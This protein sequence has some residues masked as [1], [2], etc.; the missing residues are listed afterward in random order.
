MSQSDLGQMEGICPASLLDTADR[1]PFT[2]FEALRAR[3]QVLR[4]EKLGAW[5]VLD[6]ALCREIEGNEPQFSNPYVGAPASL[7]EVKGGYGNITL[8]HGEEHMRLR[9]FHLKLLGPS[10]TARYR[11]SVVLPIIDQ[12]FRRFENRGH[13]ELVS[14]LA[15]QIPPRVIV[16]LLGMDWQDDAFIAR[17]VHLHEVIM[18]FIG[19]NYPGGETENRALAA[20]RELN[21]ILLP[22]IRARTDGK[23][24]DFIS[25][26]WA[27]A[28]TSFGAMTEETATGICRE[29]FLGGTDTTV[30]GIANCLQM[31]LTEPAL[32]TAI[33]ANRSMLV[34]FVEEAMRLY[35]SVQYRYRL[36]VEDCT[37]GGVAIAAGD[38]LV[39]VHSAANRDPAKFRCPASTDLTRR[40]A[41]DHLAFNYGIRSCVGASL[42]R[43]EM[44]ETV[45]AAM[46]R[47]PNLRLN[48]AAK[49]PRF[50][51]LF[52]RSFKPLHVLFD[53]I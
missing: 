20:S 29:I 3:G 40:P 10:Q 33:E 39:L 26:I 23:G 34:P 44:R 31:L 24:V 6:Y 50:E 35:G 52:L 47:L 15:E 12:C 43:T 28:P 32:R 16:A 21:S 19:R 38:K 53:S 9:G 7:V 5:L 46:E 13:A 42:A 37:L 18:A 2:F 25:R 48:T 41:T 11:E 51:G 45:L 27:E 14:E 30:H 8:T 17:I 22:F 1:D 49:P 36:A 4:D